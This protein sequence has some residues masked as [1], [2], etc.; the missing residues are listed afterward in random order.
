MGQCITPLS[1]RSPRA[2]TDET[3]DHRP[4]VVLCFCAIAVPDVP[5]VQDHG[6]GMCV[7]PRRLPQ[8]DDRLV[9]ADACA[10]RANQKQHEERDDRE[11]PQDSETIILSSHD[12]SSCQFKSAANSRLSAVET[13]NVYRLGLILLLIVATSWRLREPS[14]TRARLS[15]TVR[16]V[17]SL[18][19]LSAL[20]GGAKPTI[21]V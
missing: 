3:R 19:V 15:F 10:R 2:L 13:R 17:C 7:C 11:V 21:S 6:I 5:K 20:V 14:K 12:R 8:T 9:G 16:G 18:S 1:Q 4:A